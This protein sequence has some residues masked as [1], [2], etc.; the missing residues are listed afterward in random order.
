LLRPVDSPTFHKMDYPS[1]G[2]RNPCDDFRG[3]R[4]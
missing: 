3:A 1:I 2:A 4:Q